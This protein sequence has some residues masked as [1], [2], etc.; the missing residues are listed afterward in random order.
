MIQEPLM[1]RSLALD[2][3]SAEDAAKAVRVAAMHAGYQGLTALPWNRFGADW[4]TWW[5]SPSTEVPAYKC[6]KIVFTRRDSEPGS[7]FVGLYLEKGVGASAAPAFSDTKRGRSYVMTPDWTWHSVMRALRDG[8]FG[9]LVAEAEERAGRP[10]LIGVD[11][12]NMGVPT[13][14]GDARSAVRELA[15]I[16]Q[17]SHPLGHSDARA[18]RSVCRWRDIIRAEPSVVSDDMNRRAG[19]SYASPPTTPGR[20]SYE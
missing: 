9:R 5:L 16:G 15:L 19:R 2:L 6:G 4:P 3:A 7:L 20:P 14:R 10:I 18:S 11:A 17:V 12:S 13:G 1:P 8:A